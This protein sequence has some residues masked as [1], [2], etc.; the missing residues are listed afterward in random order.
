V[1]DRVVTT[2]LL[3][4]AGFFPA[5]AVEG[6][7]FSASAQVGYWNGETADPAVSTA[8]NGSPTAVGIGAMAHWTVKPSLMLVAVIDGLQGSTEKGFRQTGTR[9][10][11]IVDE[12][13]WLR[14]LDL[15][16]GVRVQPRTSRPLR[17][18]VSLLGG[19]TLVAQRLRDAPFT[20]VFT[21]SPSHEW[22]AAVQVL[23]GLEVPVKGLRVG[24]EVMWRQ[25]IGNVRLAQLSRRYPLNGWGVRLR[26]R[27]GDDPHERDSR[28]TMR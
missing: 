8:F 20:D 17:P 18:Y 10:T 5:S 23:A 15:F 12:R 24:P 25:I 26:L 11:V 21:P 9:P 27:F 1:I 22:K 7:D 16:G 4:V 28:R 3:G 13:V 6:A 19:P 14:M 2:L